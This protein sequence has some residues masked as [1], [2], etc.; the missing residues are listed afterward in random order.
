MKLPE[1][2]KKLPVFAS[3][4]I[5]FAISLFIRVVL[6]YNT[7]FKDTVRFASD[8]AVFHMRL[9][10]NALFGEHF[11]H[12]IFFDAYTHFP[13]GDYLHFAPLYDQILIFGTWLIGF[14]SPTRELMEAAGAF[15]PAILGALVVFP[16]YIIGRELCNKYAGFLAAVLVATLPGQFLQ[17]SI[18]GFT[19]HHVGEVFFSTIAVMFLILAIKK[20]KEE[21]PD[22]TVL[23]WL[24]PSE[25]LRSR[26]TPFLCYA[27]AI[28]VLFQ[29]MPLGWW[30]FIS[31]VLFLLALVI[32]SLW[33]NPNSYVFYTVLAGMALGF[34]MLTWIAG[35]FFV[36]IFFIFGVIQYT[37]SG[38]K[39]KKTDYLG[40]V[41]TPVFFIPLLM[42]I[43]F[44]LNPSYPYY[45]MVHIASLGIGVVVFGIPLLHRCLVRKEE[46]KNAP[47]K[48]K[49]LE[50]TKYICPVCGKRVDAIAEHIRIK[51]EGES[52]KNI[53]R[54][55]EFF[56]RNPELERGS[57]L[58]KEGGGSRQILVN[59]IVKGGYLLPVFTSFVLFCISLVVFPS[60]LGSFG[61]LTPSGSILTVGEV[62]SM[63]FEKAWLLFTTPFFVSFITMAVLAVNLVR[64]D[65]PE[66]CLILVWGVVVLV[67][68][69][70]LGSAG[71]IRFAY[72][73]AINVAILTGLFSVWAFE[74]LAG[75]GKGQ[76]EEKKEKKKGG[77]KNRIA[78][79]TTSKE[80]QVI[81]FAVGIMAMAVI[82]LL[83]IGVA[84]V[85]PLVAI[86]TVFFI[87]LW[88]RRERKPFVKSLTKTLAAI[89]IIFIVFYPF[90]L[91]IATSPFPSNTNLP[92]SVAYAINDAKRGIGADEE[93]YETLRWM[94]DNTPDP[95]VDYCGMYEGKFL[96]NETF[97][98][99]GVYAYPSSTY[100][101]MSWW[102]Y[103]HVITWVAHRIPNANPF[104][105]GIGGPGTTK[106]VDADGNGWY[107]EGETIVLDGDK[108]DVFDEDEEVLSVEK[109]SR[110]A[111]LS[112]FR[113]EEMYFDFDNNNRFS[114]GDAVILDNDNNNQFSEVDVVI[115]GEKPVA[116]A[117]LNVLSLI[118]GASTFL[119]ATEEI[120]ANKILNELGTRY[121]ITDFMMADFM[122]APP[123]PKYVMPIWAEK[124][125]NPW[126]TVGVRLHFFDGCG[127]EV[128]AGAVLPLTHYRLVHESPLYVIPFEVI[129]AETNKFLHWNAYFGGYEDAVEQAQILHAH[130]FDVNAEGIVDELNNATVPE[131][132]KEGFKAINFPLSEHL[133]V[134]KIK[135][136]GWVIKDEEKK[137][138]YIVEE[139]DK[140]GVN[141]YLYGIIIT[142]NP[143]MKVWT[144]KFVQPMSFVK[145]FEYVEGA[146]IRGT[147]TNATIV[148]ISTTITTSQG[149]EFVY[150]QSA[151]ADEGGKYEFVVPYSTE[152]A[153]E[154]G[155]NFD[156]YAATYKI[157]AGGVEK[158]VSV[159]E[160]AVMEG[161]TIRVDF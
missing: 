50:K 2:I 114:E 25:W 4:C 139:A 142:E 52:K 154:E 5:V 112:K 68:V 116:G 137:N 70:G 128:D 42:I 14:G 86:T 92:L 60:M 99:R 28:L 34:Y 109:P 78:S 3:L 77:G 83:K 108:N 26:N 101:V 20:A 29:V 161:K 136:G 9:V 135:E 39:G 23:K 72:Y 47:T 38:L 21:I 134:T 124:N 55:R 149:R 54:I 12:R 37:V 91:N 71:Q 57:G 148:E 145:T 146:K 158:E 62:Q 82:G 144:P 122:G 51:H 10:E 85:L 100:G 156:V 36:F 104:Q 160:E 13:Y 79:N 65:R 147:A 8:D 24:T 132:V 43:P 30:V 61:V 126:F 138:I 121:V 155:T 129:E 125:P 105:A 107:T 44:F 64:R 120:E 1:L 102:D 141:I 41:L 46:I 87:W 90:P 58:V 59:E 16:A 127:K 80:T 106:Y 84:S 113:I 66:E 96:L 159:P 94:R 40:V 63:D 35:L 31:F 157:R 98:G 150:S 130:L 74:F 11:P 89:F 73:Y 93:W 123:H 143:S 53:R 56:E 27:G 33:Q 95:G 110:K 97:E 75:W 140:G 103:G 45:Q 115:A 17:R 153:S 119:M 32:F 131:V 15:Y 69:G 76:V 117:N 19:D 88:A 118:P 81:L 7:V 22:G 18:I 67:M 48:T 111:R 152:G 6:P 151:I 49:K 133:T